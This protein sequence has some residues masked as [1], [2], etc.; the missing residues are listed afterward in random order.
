MLQLQLTASDLFR[1]AS[2]D[3]VKEDSD[4]GVKFLTLTI[5]CNTSVERDF[6]VSHF[7]AALDA[8]AE[9]EK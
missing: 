6:W 2:Y 1:V 9:R 3:G 5:A 4:E 8:M 7:Q